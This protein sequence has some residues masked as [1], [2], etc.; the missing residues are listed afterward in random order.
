[1]GAY[2][3]LNYPH[4]ESCWP[5]LKARFYDFLIHHHSEWKAIREN[6]PLDYLPYMEAKFQEVTGLKLVGLGSYT[7]WIQPGT[8]YHWVVA[9]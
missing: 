8:Y 7:G 1:M 9:K 5:S 6:T 4:A 3:R 2:Y